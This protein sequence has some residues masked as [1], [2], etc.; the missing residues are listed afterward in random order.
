M[1]KVHMY[2]HLVVYPPSRFLSHLYEDDEAGRTLLTTIAHD[3]PLY[4]LML[5]NLAV[6]YFLDSLRP[7]DIIISLLV[8]GYVS[9]F[10]VWLHQV[11]HVQG[12]WMERFLYFHDLRALHYVHHQENIQHNYGFLD[13]SCDSATNT[14][15]KA[16]YSLSNN[17]NVTKDIENSTARPEDSSLLLSPFTAGPMPTIWHNGVKE[18]IFAVTCISIE[19]IVQILGMMFGKVKSIETLQESEKKDDLLQNVCTIDDMKKTS[20]ISE[21]P[22]TYQHS[23]SV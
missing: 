2:H 13:H 8:Y 1:W 6:L 21:F 7:L 4:V 12:H 5:A 11:F 18:C 22:S 10:A 14:L 23:E 19:V 3:G 16:D 9:S 15:K 17:W 20:N